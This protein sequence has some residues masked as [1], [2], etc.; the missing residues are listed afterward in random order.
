MLNLC[1]LAIGDLFYHVE[2]LGATL[3]GVIL[4]EYQPRG[5]PQGQAFP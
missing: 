5:V 4:A 1:F 3:D 2:D